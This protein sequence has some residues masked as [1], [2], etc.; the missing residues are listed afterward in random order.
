MSNREKTTFGGR[1]KLAAALFTVSAL[2]VVALFSSASA[3]EFTQGYSSDE[4]LIRG[5]IVAIDDE[6]TNKVVLI[7][8]ERIK[9]VFGIVVRAND[10]ALTLT[11]D[12]TGVFV[13]TSGRFEVLVSD[14]NG[15]IKTGDDLTLSSIKGIGMLSDPDHITIVGTA[16][17]DFDASNPETLVLS[18]VVAKDASGTDVKISIGRIPVE[19][20]IKPNPNARRVQQVPQF[21]ASIAETITGN[22]DV[23]AFRIYSALAVLLLASAIA[24]SLLYSAVRNSIVSIGRNPLSK[25]SVLAGLAQVVVVGVI[26]F[27]SGL[28]A[29]YLIL[30][31]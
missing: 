13:T 5:S 25:K 11:S 22:S 17:A 7:S 24:G 30:K 8:D 23:S 29:V 10:S 16:L 19:I 9:D 20:G 27:L 4:P 14:I 31:I 2:F 6:D 18:S 21:L 12:R 3:Q 1:L 28:V 26:I 15:S